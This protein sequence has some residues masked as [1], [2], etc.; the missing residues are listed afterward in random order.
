M[1]ED[2]EDAEVVFEEVFAEEFVGCEGVGGLGEGAEW[3]R[4]GICGI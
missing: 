4:C 2:L 1:R 3:I